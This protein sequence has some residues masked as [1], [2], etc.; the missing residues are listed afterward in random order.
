[1]L[2]VRRAID[3][4][5]EPPSRAPF[6]DSRIWASALSI[7]NAGGTRPGAARRLH[8]AQLAVQLHGVR[9]QPRQIRL[10]VRGVLDRMVAVEESGDVEI[11]ADVLDHDVGRVAP[12]ADGDVAVR[13]REALE[14]DRVCAPNHFD[15][16]ARGVREP[17][18]VD[19]ADALQ[20][21]A[22][23]AGNPLLALRPS[24]R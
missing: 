12:A 8:P 21:R 15:A 1:M 10:R 18:G 24:D 22:H 23:L 16:G 2:A 6:A 17:R 9:L 20:V 4:T 3:S 7:R 11:R 19:R 5:S 14:R 13:K